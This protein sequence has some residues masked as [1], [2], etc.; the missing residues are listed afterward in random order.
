MGGGGWACGGCYWPKRAGRHAF[1]RL[2]RAG[3]I[4]DSIFS[5]LREPITSLDAL[6]QFGV[7]NVTSHHD[8]PSQL[9]PSPDRVPAITTCHRNVCTS[10]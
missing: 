9:Q 5:V 8:G 3:V 1:W 10:A 4:D 2:C 7:C 6:K